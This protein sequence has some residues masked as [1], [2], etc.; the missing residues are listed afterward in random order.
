[1]AV[2]EIRTRRIRPTEVNLAF[3]R[4][5]QE[6]ACAGWTAGLESKREPAEI[7]RVFNPDNPVL[8]AEAQRK[9]RA[10]ARHGR[11]VVASTMSV[12][13]VGFAMARNDVSPKDS[14]PVAL[15]ERTGKRLLS[16]A[17]H[18]HLPAPD[19]VCAWIGHIVTLPEAPDGT[20]TQLI[21]DVLVPFYPTA[22]STAYIDDENE[23]SRGFFAGLGYEWD[24][25]SVKSVHRFGEDNDP[26]VQRR[27]IAPVQGVIAAA[28]AR[29]DG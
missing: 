17:N 28:A 29:L 3:T 16:F 25:E 20:G 26:T 14:S 15:A 27:Y 10:F 23:G 18:L 21:R 1:M 24:G 4:Q 13:P 12:W 5:L 6:I 19:A 7:K 2:P 9:Y 22:T 11:L 8:V